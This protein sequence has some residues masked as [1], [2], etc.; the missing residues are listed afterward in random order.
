VEELKVMLEELDES[1]WKITN[2]LD[3]EFVFNKHQINEVTGSFS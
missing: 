2:Q 3:T 1:V